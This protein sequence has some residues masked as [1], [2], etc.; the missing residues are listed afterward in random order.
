VAAAVRWVCSPDSAA[1]TGTVV[2]ADGGFT[3]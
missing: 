2:H 1:V 3:A